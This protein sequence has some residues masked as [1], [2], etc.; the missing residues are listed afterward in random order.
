MD[1]SDDDTLE[2]SPTNMGP[3]GSDTKDSESL[4]EAPPGYNTTDRTSQMEMIS[5]DTLSGKLLLISIPLSHLS[6]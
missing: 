6:G 2:R 5:Q 4:E 3:P 1:M